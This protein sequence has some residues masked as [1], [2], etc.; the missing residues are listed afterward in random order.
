VIR[1]FHPPLRRVLL[2]YAAICVALWFFPVLQIL[3]VESA[4]VVSF[5]AFFAAG[6]SSLRL[7]EQGWRKRDVLGAQEAALLV[8]WAL[9][10]VSALWAPNCGYAQG[11]LFFLLFPVVTVVAAVAGAYA[12]LASGIRRKRTVL[13]L[14]GLSVAALGPLY[15]LGLHPQFYTYNH[16]FGGVLGPIYDEQL[17]I[18]P[19][20][21]V[22]RGLTLLWAVLLF[23][24][25]AGRR[26]EGARSGWAG[27]PAAVATVLPIGLAYLFSAPMGINTPG[28]FIQQELGGHYRTEH[29]DLY[30]DPASMTASG[31]QAVALDHEYQYHRLADLLDV[32]VDERI[33]SY[34]YPDVDTKARL[35]GAR[36]TSVAPTWL[37]TPQT[38]VIAAQYEGVFPHELAHV[39]SREFGLPVL[40]ASVAVGLV[41]GLAVALEPPSGLPSPHEQ[42]LAALMLASEEGMPDAAADVAARLSPLGF[43]TGR[44]AVSYTTM[45]SFV[46]YLLQAYGPEPLKNAYAGGNFQE[47]YGKP[48]TALARE[49]QSYLAGRPFTAHSAGPIVLR[50]FTLPSLFEVLCPHHV[51]DYVLYYQVGVKALQEEDS[52]AALRQFERALEERSGFAQGLAAWAGLMLAEGDAT[53]VIN[54]LDGVVLDELSASVDFAL[55]DAYAMVGDSVQARLYYERAAGQVIYDTEGAR[56]LL[57]LRKVMAGQADAIRVLRSGATPADKHSALSQFESWSAGLAMLAALE[58][59]EAG[60]YA[61]AAALLEQTD[62]SGLTSV[63]PAD[64]RLLERQRLAWLARFHYL[65]GTYDAAETYAARARAEYRVVGDF[66]GAAAAELIFD[67]VGWVRGQGSGV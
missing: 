7:F 65:S 25:G 18:R 54:R 40:R 53:P 34:L 11:L 55:G 14:G 44:G 19:G 42:M 12:L 59:A 28:W 36:Y 50:Q 52:T 39:F 62:V 45:G 32:E 3:H 41:E 33:V 26:V 56:S 17:A 15:D 29:F 2:V 67:K 35:T 16:V 47:V 66:D 1:L 63:T 46:G 57:L 22:F 64:A 5:T 31:V 6:L 49:W 23:Q 27:P 8:P 37:R 61:D 38:H 60:S 43:W 58:W 48:V 20:L 4:A 21:F 30:Y 10:T 51:P 9:L 13:I 24:I